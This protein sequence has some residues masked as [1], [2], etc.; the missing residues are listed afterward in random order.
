M[1]KIKHI[2]ILNVFS[3]FLGF[4]GTLFMVKGV[5]TSSPQDIAN[6]GE[7]YLGMNP[8]FLKDIA[9]SRAD[10]ICGILMVS[11][12]F[13]LQIVINLV[14]NKLEDEICILTK[15]KI[16]YFLSMLF[17]LC[18]FIAFVHSSINKNTIFLTYKQIAIS[19]LTKQYNYNKNHQ[20]DKNKKVVLSKGQ[21]NLLYK[22]MAD[23]DFNINGK[24]SEIDRVKRFYEYLDLKIENNIELE[25]SVLNFKKKDNNI[26]N[27]TGDTSAF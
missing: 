13:F 2:T 17:V 25:K 10:A 27:R 4:I 7:S 6:L 11:S 22:Y 8:F 16:L 5:I 21:V 3:A 26:I 15:N 1:N 14:G 23:L 18:I 20:A 24:E 12:S 9:E 19:G